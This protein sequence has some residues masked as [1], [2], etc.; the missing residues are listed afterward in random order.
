MRGSH[1]GRIAMRPYELRADTCQPPDPD[2]ARTV[3]HDPALCYTADTSTPAGQAGVWRQTGWGPAAMRC[4][5]IFA[6]AFLTGFSGAMMPGPLLA[7]VIGQVAAV[8]LS[9]VFWLITGHALLELLT[10]GLLAAGLRHVVARPKV[11]GGIGLVGGLAL[12]YMGVDMVR[13]APHLRIGLEQGAAT[14]WG[15]L[16]L[17]GAV[18]CAA[19]PFF[20]GWWATVGVGQMAHTAPRTVG[21]YGAFYLGHEMSDLVWYTIVGLLIVGGRQ[22]LHGAWYNWLVG[23]CGAAI[24]VLAI[25]FLVTGGKL[26]WARPQPQGPAAA[27]AE[28]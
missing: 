7:L 19:N 22:L 9:A 15:Q 24:V 27:P 26:I 12:L 25:I 16:I 21:E 1:L 28:E 11:R 17:A 4:G 3:Y 20:T 13:S 6:L 14:P 10:V 2:Q 5:R 23:T 8:G 18:V